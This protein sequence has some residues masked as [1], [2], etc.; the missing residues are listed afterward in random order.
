MASQAVGKVLS[1]KLAHP[2]AIRLS[3]GRVWCPIKGID[4]KEVGENM[5]VFRFNQESGKKRALEDGPWMFEKDLVVVEDYDP[6]KRPED[7]AFN[8]VPIWVRIFSLP[9]GMMNVHAAEVI[10]NIIGTYV[11]ADVGGNGEAMGRF[12]RVKIR[13]NIDKPIMR[14]IMLDEAFMGTGQK[15]KRNMNIDGGREEEEE[16]WCRF[17]YVFLPD[18]CYVCGLVG[19]SDKMCERRIEKGE[20][21]QFGSWFRADMGRRKIYGEEAGGWRGRGRGVGGVKSFGT[22]KSQDRSGS[23]SDSLS[24]RKD[25]SRS[26]EGKL[27][28]AEKGEE[29]TSPVKQTTS[30]ERERGNAKRH[31]MVDPVGGADVG[32]EAQE[33]AHATETCTHAEGTYKS[34]QAG[35]EGASGATIGHLEEGGRNLVLTHAEER[36]AEAGEGVIKA[37]SSGQ[38]RFKRIARGN[39]GSGEGPQLQGNI[40]GHKRPQDSWL[41]EEEAKRSRMDAAVVMEEAQRERTGLS[42]RE[43]EKLKWKLGLINMIAWSSEGRSRGVALFWRKE[44]RLALRSYG[45]RHIDVDVTEEDRGVWRLTGIYGESEAERKKETW[46][47]MRLLGQQHQWG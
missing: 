30:V 22:S 40:A 24:W 25:T 3:L 7:Y 47:T 38:K 28:E 46:R 19:H 8:E 23:G 26:T 16:A 29:V 1:E 45:R 4:Y 39:G 13:M 14:G 37:K 9:L 27:V 33:I 31:L 2:D 18:F 44:V 21:A 10:G 34:S 6:G 20:Q 5:F 36:E 15:Q 12:M 43:M 11:E 32:K 41:G 35:V 42:D 17:E